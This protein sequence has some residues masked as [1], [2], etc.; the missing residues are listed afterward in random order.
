MRQ[1]GIIL[2]IIGLMLGSL[3]LLQLELSPANAAPPPDNEGGVNYGTDWNVTGQEYRGNQTIILDGNLTVEPG[4]NLTLFNVTLIM[5]CS[6]D[7]EFNIDVQ[8]GGAMWILSGS[9]ITSG[10]SNFEYSFWVRKE[11]K[12]NMTDSE[13]HR[14]GGVT[15]D[16]NNTFIKNST[17]TYNTRCV[18][19]RSS[20]NN[21][22]IDSDI[23]LNTWGIYY[24]NSSDGNNVIN[25]SVYF[26]TFGI[27]FQDS[28][29]NSITTCNITGNF[30]HSIYLDTS[31]NNKVQ[32]CNI[33]NNLGQG[34]FITYG[35]NFNNINNCN[36]SNNPN[37]GT[38]IFYSDRNNIL[39][40]TFINNSEG[41]YLS[42]SHKNF[43]I[44]NTIISNNYGI[45][46]YNSNNNTVKNSTVTFSE[47]CG[48]QVDSSDFNIFENVTVMNNINIPGFELYSSNNNT[49]KNC[50]IINNSDGIYFEA[51]NFNKILNCEIKN[52]DG[53]G[54][55]LGPYYDIRFSNNNTIKY[56]T[57]NN[58]TDNNLRLKSA[59]NNKIFNCNFSES[60]V[61]IFLYLSRNN[62]LYGNHLNDNSHNFGVA[63]NVIED[64][65]NNVD[66]SNLVNGKSIYY[67]KN[68]KDL[69]LP[70]DVGYVGLI[71]SKNISLKNIAL[72][73]NYQGLLLVNTSH[74]KIN[75]CEFKNNVWGINS[76]LRSQNNIINN[77]N[78][79]NN[80]QVGIEL[81]GSS[82]N[83]IS[84]CIIYNN[85]YWG[86]NIEEQS[87]NPNNI[88]HSRN[89]SIYDC[90]IEK[91]GNHGILLRDGNN[92]IETSKIYSNTNHGIFIT[93]SDNE[94]VNCEIINNTRNGIQLEGSNALIDSCKILQNENG[95][96]LYHFDTQILFSSNVTIANCNISK[97]MKGIEIFRYNLSSI[98]NCKLINNTQQGIWL[99]T[100]EENVIY[101]NLIKN[102]EHGVYFDPISKYNLIY[103]NNFISN[104]YQVYSAN[105]KNSFNQE[106]P[107]CGNY[108]SDYEEMW[109][110]EYPD[111]DQY[112]GITK[113]SEGRDCIGDFE[114][115][116]GVSSVYDLYPFIYYDGWY[117]PRISP[118]LKGPQESIVTTGS[119]SLTW[120][121][122]PN[123]ANYTI[124]ESG[125]GSFSNPR[126]ITKI[127]D[128][129]YEIINQPD[130][131][132]YYRVRAQNLFGNS[133]WSNIVKV[134]VDRVPN[135][136]SGLKVEQ[137]ITGNELK[138]NWVEN[139]YDTVNYT[140]WSNQTSEWVPLK[141]FSH[142]TTEF[143]DTKL[144]DGIRYYY[145]LQAWDARGLCSGFTSVASNISIDKVAP[146]TP[147]NFKITEVTTGTI[148]LTW[149]PNPEPDLMGYH[150]FKA[151]SA[152]GVFKK[153]NIDL[154]N[155]TSYMDTGLS[156]NT[157]YFYKLLAYDE[158]PN[159]SYYT[160]IINETTLPI[161]DLTNPIVLSFLPNGTDVFP[162]PK[163]KVT[164]NE[165][166]N[167]NSVNN[168]FSIVPNVPGEYSWSYDDRTFIFDPSDKLTEGQTYN[169]TISTKAKDLAGNPLLSPL[170]WNFT[171]GDYTSPEIMGYSP[172]GTEVPVDSV[173]EVV[174]SEELDLEYITSSAILLKD[175]NGSFVNGTISYENLTLT[176]TPTK[177]LEPGST[178]TVLVNKLL[179]DPAGNDL[180]TELSWKFTT[181]DEPTEPV[182]E[183][184]KPEEYDYGCAGITII[185]MIIFAIVLYMF[186]SKTGVLRRKP[187]P[188]IEWDEE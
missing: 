178:Y 138:I 5:N 53:N 25:C 140:I 44:N 71:N 6:Y 40:N 16:A 136:P 146:S 60:N 51:S 175:Q 94:I 42:H 133:S 73:N 29:N 26:N 116:D 171:I 23:S 176:F 74:S 82:F 68:Q 7:G 9:N 129:F 99:R 18:Y 117:P 17:L 38:I 153:I 111:L 109:Q 121:Y 28:S 13:L 103:H 108:W 143:I 31:K 90:L 166:M 165:Y 77:C 187:P 132:Y 86:I 32:F 135:T 67:L 169:V 8:T 149:S 70:I 39:N 96:E 161:L 142:P 139:Y 20:S 4:G 174:F 87:N 49:I 130:G 163:I 69:E 162:Y 181:V 89:N 122:Q 182:T 80:I 110:D 186:L 54:I 179:K 27:Y 52:N 35:S 83:N 34:I 59:N 58:N 126:S 78:V 185:V 120:Q 92:K 184:E 50:D 147:A 11:S 155:G 172:N 157:T 41:I 167:K 101:Y 105:D 65:Y 72:N 97:N 148:N 43:I 10:N 112:S 30:F 88:N 100:A 98:E 180:S 47:S 107:I 127:E 93:S 57:F 123:A 22:I 46:L 158:V 55:Y 164:F 125:D 24:Y 102:N 159:Y 115:D 137:I 131:T 3:Q 12:F 91:N 152:D 79:T 160:E 56:C 156:S 62:L 84:K 15:I 150:I 168:S 154:I 128:T 19:Y 45:D 2:V 170:S 76:N 124:Q 141:N 106:Y 61:G 36:I 144:T 104:Y 64:Y 1:W 134:V 33:T 145:K 85:S 188:E 21:Y 81:I 63:G 177:D 75:N 66:T 183:D 151:S 173:I 14:S 114:Y 37:S 95:I 113:T 119:F 48:I 118:I